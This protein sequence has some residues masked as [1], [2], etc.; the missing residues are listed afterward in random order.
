MHLGDLVNIQLITHFLNIT[1]H[2]VKNCIH[3]T[4]FQCKLHIHDYLN[5]YLLT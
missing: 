3:F 5:Q 2:Y 1:N 4:K